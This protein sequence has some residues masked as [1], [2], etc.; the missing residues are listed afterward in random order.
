MTR[1][2]TRS[3]R[4]GAEAKARVATILETL[5]LRPLEPERSR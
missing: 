4:H 1:R 3:S 2:W 5:E